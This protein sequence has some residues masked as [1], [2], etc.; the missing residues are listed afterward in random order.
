M[1]GSE[2]AGQPL[3]FMFRRISI[4]LN[5]VEKTSLANPNIKVYINSKEWYS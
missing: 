1:G 4:G 5:D 2:Q 3:T